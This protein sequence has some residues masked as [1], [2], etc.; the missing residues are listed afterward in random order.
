MPRT[1]KRG[2]EG[3]TTT[4]TSFLE[5]VSTDISGTSRVQ[6]SGSAKEETEESTLGLLKDI[7][8]KETAKISN[9]LKDIKTV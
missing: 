6:G 5:R 8:L 3:N 9:E 7:L 2:L 4:M 1:R